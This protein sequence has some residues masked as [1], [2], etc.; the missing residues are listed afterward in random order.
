MTAADQRTIR[1][2]LLL[3]SSYRKAYDRLSDSIR[4]ST[5]LSF[6][7]YV[8]LLDSGNG[9][10]GIAVKDVAKLT[11]QSAERNAQS[12]QQLQQHGLIFIT[13]DHQD[14]RVRRIQATDLGFRF[15]S[16]ARKSVTQRL[17]RAYSE[18]PSGLHGELA[19]LFQAIAYPHLDRDDSPAQPQNLLPLALVLHWTNDILFSCACKAGLTGLQALILLG[20]TADEE[21]ISYTKLA[22]RLSSDSAWLAASAASLEALGAV[23]VR[24][25]PDEYGIV[26]S[27]EG[28]RLVE[29]F[30]ETL[31]DEAS[32]FD[33]LFNNKTYSPALRAALMLS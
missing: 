22:D 4:R 7:H 31:H 2:D 27:D 24:H 10:S 11:R 3:L 5:G 23:A 19:A 28:T 14:R 16:I 12:V 26:L 32:T 8:I 6:E 18:L 1:N 15:I 30:V 33:E 17:L 20:L 25:N 29:R 13:R 21:P 9:E